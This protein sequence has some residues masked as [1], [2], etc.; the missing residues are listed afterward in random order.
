MRSFLG[1][2]LVCA[3]ALANDPLLDGYRAVSDALAHDKFSETSLLANKLVP[4]IDQWLTDHAVSDA[5]TPYVQKLRAGAAK[6]AETSVEKELRGHFA[7]F[8]EGATGYLKRIAAHEKWQLYRCPMVQGFGY[9]AQPKTD[10]MANP[11]M[12]LE[13]LTCGAKRPWSSIP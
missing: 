6:M 2:I 12:G 1:L 11:F 9:W 8:S 3:N 10:P 7:L 13:M 4:D 5:K